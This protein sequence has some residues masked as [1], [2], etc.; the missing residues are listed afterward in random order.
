MR[1]ISIIYTKTTTIYVPDLQYI[2]TLS[3]LFSTKFKILTIAS[4]LCPSYIALPPAAPS[5]VSGMSSPIH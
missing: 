5:S 4:I 2:L 3:I 1:F